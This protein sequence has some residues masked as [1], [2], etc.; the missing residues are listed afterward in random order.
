MHQFIIICQCWLSACYLIVTDTPLWQL[1]TTDT[2]PDTNP[3]LNTT[4][5]P[6]QIFPLCTV[7]V[8]VI[9]TLPNWV[10][11]IFGTTLIMSSC[12]AADFSYF[13]GWF[14]VFFY[15]VIIFCCCRIAVIYPIHT[16]CST[17]IVGPPGLIVLLM[18]L[19]CCPSLR[20][21]IWWTLIQ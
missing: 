9:K 1:L 17:D 12:R 18:Y 3:N 6:N 8:I 5:N 15:Y 7:A 20:L 4:T 10:A 19:K 11:V 2:K 13:V 16:C 14:W 21:K